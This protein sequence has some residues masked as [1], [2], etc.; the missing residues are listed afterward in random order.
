MNDESWRGDLALTPLPQVLR[1]IWEK[2]DT[3]ELRIQSEAGDRSA[4]FIKGDLALAEG[5]FSPDLFIK[6][7]LSSQILTPLQAE[8]CAR[9]AGEK[10]RS[11]PRSLIEQEIVPPFRV[12][13][14]L[15]DSWRKEWL[16][17]FDWP[18]GA[19]AFQVMAPL[20]DAKIYATFPTP[21]VILAGIR[22]MKN[23][24]LIEAFLPAETESLQVLSAAAS[25]Q[26]ELAPHETHVLRALRQSPRL[27]DLYAVSQA[28]RR[29][30][31]KAVFAFLSLGLTGA[32][33]APGA[34]KPAPDFSAAGLEKT[35]NSFN[36]KCSF[37]Y[38]YISK[39]IGPVG[40]SVLEKALEEVRARLTPPFQGLELRADGRVEFSPFPLMSL[41]LSNQ[42]TRRNFIRLL[43][44][45]LVTEVLAVKKTLGNAHE[46]VVVRSLEKIG[47]PS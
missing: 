33:Q 30:T 9:Y 20:E 42:E 41:I 2:R 25:V 44:E 32:H 13:E 36:D 29:E 19:V 7:L 1:R 12:W 22:E 18:R 26:L 4:Y 47:E 31:Q 27:S 11:Y 37:I 6:T 40:L 35:W 24:H 8:E 38:K 3:G 15:T 43:N 10:N 5:Y 46:A 16:A 23:H 45:I 34:A 14:S 21:A 39:E 17:V 28:G